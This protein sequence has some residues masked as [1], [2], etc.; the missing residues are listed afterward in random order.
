MRQDSRPTVGLALAVAWLATVGRG[1]TPPTA[2]PKP[3]ARAAATE[4]PSLA[5]PDPLAQRL[6][7]ALHALP[8]KRKGEC[9]GAAHT[10]SLAGLCGQELT[11]SVRRGAVTIDA[12]GTA[13]CA[14]ETARQLE[15]CG[16]VT[17]L[18]PQ[19]PQACSGLMHGT[20]K[21]GAACHS[22]L[23]CVDGLYCRGVGPRNTGVCG[24]PAAPRRRCE[25]P[26]D[27]LA[28]FTGAKGDPRHPECQGRCVKGLCLPFL[29]PGAACASSGLCPPGLNC[30]AGRC[31]DRPLPKL[32]EA[33]S[34]RTVCE[35][36]ASCHGGQ[37]KALKNAG[38]PCAQPFECRAL[39]CVKAPGA[40][41]GTCGEPC[42]AVPV[43][44][45]VPSR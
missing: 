22:S 45:G 33:C 1:E 21:A 23:E 2:S 30:I 39:R 37:C 42:A 15:G 26:A 25:I 11:A 13:K 12:A 7:D 16:W 20:L 41:A 5:K 4:S 9:C 10:S 6:C 32:G 3:P 27:N 18:L 19:Q 35:A 28:A 40:R 44:P 43:A 38:E 14:E 24:A 29:A 31:Q 34:G 8:A 36:G 17:P